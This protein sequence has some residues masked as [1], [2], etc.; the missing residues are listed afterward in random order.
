[1]KVAIVGAGINGLYLSW[2][3]SQ[4]GHDVT[5]FEKKNKIG[6]SACS[7]LFSERIFEFIP[8]SRGLVQ[9]QINSVLV[10]LPKKNFKI[11]FSKK[12]FVLSHFQ[13]DNVVAKLAEGAGAKIILENAVNDIPQGFDRVIGCDGSN[14]I[15]RK[16]LGLREP[17]FRLGIRGFI[18]QEDHSDFVEG[19]PVTPHHFFRKD[20][21]G[22]I[23]KIPRGEETEYGIITGPQRAKL[24]FDDFL[25]KNDLQ[26]NK[27]ESATVPQDFLVPRNPKITLC[28][29]AIG[30][31]KPWS[32]GG[33]IWGLIGASILLKNFPDFLKYQKELK[34][35]FL[36]KISFS[37]IATKMAYSI[38]FNF[39]WIIPQNVKIEGDFLIQ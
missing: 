5:V 25:R 23:W 8:Q 33:V 15:I 4:M 12:F 20:G 31:T 34:R 35:F 38:G 21:G 29:D 11:Y 36:P 6:K 32:G 16:K 39:P 17:A 28:G 26:L 14:S 3:L 10:H 9:N 19:W 37:R 22:F 18:P 2:K 7:G 13:L 30:L 27:L 24:L 1:M